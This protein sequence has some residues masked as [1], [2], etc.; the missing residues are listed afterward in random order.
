MR[1]R[2]SRSVPLV[3]A[4]L[5]LGLLVPAAGRSCSICRCG[6]PTFNALGADGYDFPGF[7]SAFDWERFDKEEGDSSEESEAQVENRMTALLSWGV[8]DRLA[9][10]ARFPYS[11]RELTSREG[12]D[13]EEVR[14]N[15]LSDP[16]TYAQLR[17]WSSP[18]NGGTGMRMSLSAQAGVKTPWGENDLREDGERVDE[19]AQPGTGSTDVFGGL[20]FLYL[21]DARSAFFASS[22]YRHTGENDFGYRYGSSVLANA[23]YE[24]KL[25]KRV[26]AVCELNLRHAEQDR[27]DEEGALADTGGTLLYVTPRL[28]V[29]V[30]GGVVLRVASQLPLARD[31]NGEQTERAVLNAGVTALLPR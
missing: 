17:L 26:D 7:R 11:I 23:A 29:N 12:G 16:E 20:T 9:L 3:L 25:G 30:G 31:L 24:R 13:V 22:A 28:L 21:I 15:G 8:D 19:H 2:V 27:V 14:T 10:F 18:F 6:D 1:V 5:V 4:S